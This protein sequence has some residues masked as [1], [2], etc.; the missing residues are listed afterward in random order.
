M[1]RYKNGPRPT[2]SSVCDPSNNGV[3]A[4]VGQT[5]RYLN[6]EA[7]LPLTTLLGED[8]AEKECPAQSFNRGQFHRSEEHTSELQSRGHLVCRLLLE[9]KKNNKIVVRKRS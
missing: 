3:T 4:H 6:I 2:P 7:V 8:L 1:E 5:F 9:K